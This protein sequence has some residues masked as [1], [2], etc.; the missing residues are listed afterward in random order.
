MASSCQIC[1]GTLLRISRKPHSRLSTRL[2]SLLHHRCRI[3]FLAR[4]PCSPSR[5]LPRRCSSRD[6]VASPAECHHLHRQTSVGRTLHPRRTLLQCRIIHT[7]STINGATS[8]RERI[9]GSIKHRTLVASKTKVTAKIRRR[10]KVVSQADEVGMEG[11]TRVVDTT[12]EVVTGVD[13]EGDTDATSRCALDCW[14]ARIQMMIDCSYLE[15]THHG[16]HLPLLYF[17]HRHFT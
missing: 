10:V 13:E 7:I 9:L 4:S 6:L 15:Y 5:R 2:C 16:A 1:L 17:E 11:T 8:S 12:T 3:S 14:I